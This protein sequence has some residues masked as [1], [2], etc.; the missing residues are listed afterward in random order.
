MILWPTKFQ[1]GD[2]V[3]IP[4]ATMVHECIVAE[5]DGRSMSLVGKEKVGMWFN[6]DLW[7]KVDEQA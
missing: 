7:E 2:R 5:I 3:R 4:G 1:P 6:P